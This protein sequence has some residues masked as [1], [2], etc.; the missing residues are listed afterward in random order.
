M[1]AIAAGS[2]HNLALKADGTVGAWGQNAEGQGSVPAGLAGVTAIA[3]GDFHNA[4][5][6]PTGFLPGVSGFRGVP[7]ARLPDTRPA[8]VTI[9]G[10]F[11][12]RGLVGPG[13]TVDVQIADRAG[14][15][16]ERVGAVV[17]NITAVD[18]TAPTFGPSSQR[19]HRGPRPRI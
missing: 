1:V 4:V 18:A 6:R 3:A 11:A 17:L 8:G 9:D 13:T 12:R 5:V 2:D 19:E 7:P 16:I 15:P 14:I 10:T